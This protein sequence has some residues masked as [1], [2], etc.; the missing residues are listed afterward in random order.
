MAYYMGT[1]FQE[2]TKRL[3]AVSS[4]L[5]YCII[6]LVFRTAYEK[7]TSGITALQQFMSDFGIL[8]LRSDH[9]RY[10][11]PQSNTRRER[12]PSLKKHLLRIHEFSETALPEQTTPSSR[13]G[14]ATRWLRSAY[15]VIWVITVVTAV[16]GYA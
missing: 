1:S 9:R 15:R 4:E 10:Y 5:W 3:P 14:K 12:R 7:K 11:H 6:L 2:Q 8:K 13:A 16:Q